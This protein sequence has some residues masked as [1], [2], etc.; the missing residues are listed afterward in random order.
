[1][2]IAEL[3]GKLSVKEITAIKKAADFYRD[4]FVEEPNK[5]ELLKAIYELVDTENNNFN[6][7]IKNQITC[8][9]GCAFCCH[10]KVS[11]TT[12]ETDG[13]VKYCKEKEIS[14][15]LELLEKQKDIETPDQ[16]NKIRHKKCVFLDTDNT[17]KI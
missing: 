14:I 3:M 9:K 12:L 5:Y 2:E 16:W 1:M 8:K 17:C 11:A 13:I 6:P 7:Q 10:I 15:D 4:Q